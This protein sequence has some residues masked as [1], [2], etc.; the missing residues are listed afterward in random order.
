MSEMIFESKY[1]EL[2]KLYK[3]IDERLRN[4]S[5]RIH[6]QTNT[7]LSYYDYLTGFLDNYE[8]EVKLLLSNIDNDLLE[9]ISLNIVLIKTIVQNYLEGSIMDSMLL[10]DIIV[11]LNKGGKVESEK[12][13]AHKWYKGRLFNKGHVFDNNSDR[14]TPN[15]MSILPNDLRHLATTM[16]YSMLGFPCLYL[17][18]SVKDCF[19]ECR[20]SSND[21]FFVAEFD[22]KYFE[23]LKIADFRVPQF[24]RN[25]NKIKEDLKT[26][27]IVIACSI[28]VPYEKE[29]AKFKD[30]YIFPQL[31]MLS[32][33]KNDE[34]DACVYTSVHREDPYNEDN[35]PQWDNIAIPAKDVND[36][37]FKLSADKVRAVDIEVE[38]KI[39]EL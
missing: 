37:L 7:V 1:E 10:T 3:K 18:S 16:R 12:N 17:G 13:Q 11:N 15:E 38:C 21:K 20:A 25:D 27:P 8:K 6:T 5:D 36:N 2:E 31:L 30:E 24:E 28:K 14:P 29:N 34:V 23:K 19:K 4:Q 33:K 32:I 35:I 9:K 26:W 39:K 22:E